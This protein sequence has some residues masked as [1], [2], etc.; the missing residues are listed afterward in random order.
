MSEKIKNSLCKR[1]KKLRLSGMASE[2]EKQSNDPNIGVFT[3]E[4]RLSRIIM[5]EEEIRFNN[6]LN[7]YL[8]S[9][10]L[11]YPEAVINP[12]IMNEERGIDTLVLEKLSTCEWIDERKNVIITGPTGSGKSYMGCALGSAAI[13]K[14]KKVKYIRTSLLLNELKKA[15]DENYLGTKLQELQKI[16]LLILDDFAMME[17]NIYHCRSLFELLESR[18]GRYSTIFISQY[19]VSAWYE[20][21]SDPTFADACL[22]RA[23]HRAYRLELIGDSLRNRI[24]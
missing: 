7:R 22:D 10:G 9:A 14:F 3:V 16:D 8:K 20:L 2:L 15:E 12:Q 21:F 18:D 4:E 23:L 19:P 5:A 17:L 1:L 11:R 6:K 24:A 13:Q